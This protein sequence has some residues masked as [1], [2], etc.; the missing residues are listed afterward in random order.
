MDYRLFAESDLVARL[1]K[2]DKRAGEELHER[3]RTGVERYCQCLM[4]NHESAR[5]AAQDT[6]LKAALSRVDWTPPAE[7]NV[8]QMVQRSGSGDYFGQFHD[9]LARPWRNSR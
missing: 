7:R 3:Y 1:Q 6:F 2:G 9:P 5:D 4:H 8:E